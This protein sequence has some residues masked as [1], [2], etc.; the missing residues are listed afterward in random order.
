MTAQRLEAAR[1]MLEDGFSSTELRSVLGAFATGVT[2]ITSRGSE[3][4]YGMT[5][6]AFT[7]VSLD[8]PL[9]LVCVNSGT[10]G[11]QTIER[12]RTFAVNVLGTHQEPISRYFA[13]RD[14]PRGSEAFDEIPH[15]SA[16]T[17]CPI[18][19]G[20]AAYLDCRLAASHEAG[21]HVIHIGEVLAVGID[22][23][24]T[25]LLFH[26]GRYCKVVHAES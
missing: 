19:E 6:N 17:G 7:S 14:R 10:T 24:V 13:A 3:H 15:R 8:P 22:E 16:V 25:P 11:T 4:A 26:H 23:D 20:A 1:S 2:V 9:V 21:D 18:I 5:A 12:N